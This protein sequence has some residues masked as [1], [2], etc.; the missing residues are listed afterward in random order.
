MTTSEIFSFGGGGKLYLSRK[1]LMLNC[2]LLVAAKPVPACPVLEPKTLEKLFE[3]SLFEP[4]EEPS[5]PLGLKTDIRLGVQ[6]PVL[7]LVPLSDSIEQLEID[8]MLL[9]DAILFILGVKPVP[10]VLG[11]GGPKELA[12]DIVLFIV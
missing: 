10:E 5:T 11:S 1:L 7:G 9:D 6:K 3:V 8:I 12:I 2:N 4:L